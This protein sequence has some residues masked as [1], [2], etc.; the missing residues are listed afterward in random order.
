MTKSKEQKTTSD[1][2]RTTSD[3]RRGIRRLVGAWACA[4]ALV[5]CNLTD[6][7]PPVEDP[8]GTD[9]GAAACLEAAA[10]LP[11]ICLPGMYFLADYDQGGGNVVLVDDPV[12]AAGVGGGVLVNVSASADWVGSYEFD[13]GECTVGCGWCQPGQSFCYKDYDEDGRPTCGLCLGPEVADQATACADFLLACQGIDPTGDPDTSGDAGGGGADDT[14]GGDQTGGADDAGVVEY[15]CSAWDPRDAVL[16]ERGVAYLDLAIAGEIA[17]HYGDPLALCDD[18]RFTR[19]TTGHY[20]IA[21]MTSTGV[22]AQMGLRPGDVI[23][24]ANGAPLATLDAIADMTV[25]I[26]YGTRI[27][28]AFSLAYQR[29]RATHQIKV[30]VE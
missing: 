9:G 14:G 17:E 11:N 18:T 21:R 27:D 19:T 5:G 23:L 22:L 10:E 28:R 16:L 26:F 1:E 7:Q 13:G 15:D 20:S 29:G 12:A 4:V 30:I 8:G 24:S 6:D 3:E 25:D 2:R